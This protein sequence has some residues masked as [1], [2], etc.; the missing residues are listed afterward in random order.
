V[1][2]FRR[3]STTRL[4]PACLLL[5]ASLHAPESL[6]AQQDS[7]SALL[8]LFVLDCGQLNR[9]EPVRYNLTTADV[10]NTNFSDPCFL[11]RH[12]RGTLL[13]DLGIIPDDEIERGLT[14]QPPEGGVGSNQSFRTLR[15]QLRELGLSPEDITHVAMSHSH[16]DHMANANDYAGAIW[17]VQREEW[18]SMF[19]DEA[20]ARTVA[21]GGGVPYARY[22]EL[23]LARTLLLSGDHDVFGDDSVVILRPPCHTPGHQSLMV[24]LP[25]HGVVILS[26]DLYHYAPERTLDRMP[27]AERTC[28]TPGT[29][30]SRA[31]VERLLEETRGELWI[32]HDIVHYAELD[33]APSFYR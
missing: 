2:A 24:R 9:G 26:G 8:R 7:E 32:Q 31:R 29:S 22:N 33:K 23:E 25:A 16:A 20:R 11:V 5:S 27:N 10:G 28:G 13:W 15:S 30:E 4:L 3:G 14:I 17:I 1:N 12:P 6:S 18:R 19:S 21:S